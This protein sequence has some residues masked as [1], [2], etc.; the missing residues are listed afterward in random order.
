MEWIDDARD[1]PVVLN[2]GFQSKKRL[3]TIIF[4]HAGPLVVDIFFRKDN[5]DRPRLHRNST[6]K[7]C[8]GCPGTTVNRENHKNIVT[9]WQCCSPQSKGHSPVSGGRKITNPAPPT[10]Q[11][12][13]CT[14]WLLAVFHFENWPCWTGNSRPCKSGGFTTSCYTPLHLEYHNAV[15]K[16]LSRQQVCVD[17]NGE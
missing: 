6:A 11:P 9:P 5:N 8:C 10:L 12:W 7:S 13:L 16:W 15:Q 3:F 4:K 14:M 17:S 1:R 2:P